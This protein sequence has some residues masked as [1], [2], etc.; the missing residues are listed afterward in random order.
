M[1]N[2]RNSRIEF[3]RILSMLLITGRHVANPVLYLTQGAGYYINDFICMSLLWGGKLGVVIFF[4]I[5]AWFYAGKNSSIDFRKILFLEKQTL[6]WALT[7]LAITSM[8]PSDYGFSR[9]SV[10]SLIVNMFPTI[11][12]R[13]WYVTAYIFFLLLLP[14]LNRMLYSLTRT[15][16]LYL[17][18]MALFLGWIYPMLPVGIVFSEY[19]VFTFLFIY[20]CI[21]Y[22]RR[23]GQEENVF[24]S[25]PMLFVYLTL[26]AFSSCV[27]LWLIVLQGFDSAMSLATAFYTPTNPVFLGTAAALTKMMS[28]KSRHIIVIDALAS[29]MF[30][31][32]ILQT[33][34][35][36][37]GWLWDTVALSVLQKYTYSSFFVVMFAALILMIVTAFC[38]VEALRKLL[39]RL[40]GIDML[41]YSLGNKINET[42]EVKSKCIKKCW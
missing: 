6:F 12:N 7:I 36:I 16:H 21:A 19:S 27:F 25:S 14:V 8:I 20:I 33:N 5:S 29:C 18:I 38:S 1:S 2:Y 34:I 22:T 13:W 41:I 39:F 4:T 30:G 28:M 40:L 26:L 10:K 35:L 31:V 42:I 11:F 37:S 17:C 3:L 24:L 32:Y 9:F 15:M 23:Y